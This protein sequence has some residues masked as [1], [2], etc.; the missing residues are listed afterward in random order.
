M[1]DSNEKKPLKKGSKKQTTNSKVKKTSK[2]NSKAKNPKKVVSSTKTEK[3]NSTISKSETKTLQDAVKEDKTHNQNTTVELKKIDTPEV[4]ED[5]LPKIHGV[6]VASN[7][8]YTVSYSVNSNE[9]K[10]SLISKI[11][12]FFKRLF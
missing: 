11:R 10:R 12:N 4:K 1:A 2:S 6:D 5:S 7:E 8:D 3:Q 9:E